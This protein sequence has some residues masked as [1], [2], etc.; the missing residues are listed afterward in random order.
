MSDGPRIVGGVESFLSTLLL[1]ACASQQPPTDS[2]SDEA[3]E[4]IDQRA[5]FQ[6]SQV[7]GFKTLD[8]SNLIVYA[9][10]RTS[11]YHVRIR[12]PARELKFAN[13]IAFDTGG[14]RICGRVGEGV[15]FE[16][17]GMGRKYFVTDVYRLDEEARQNLISSFSE[18]I[19]VE[20]QEEREL[21][22]E[23]DIE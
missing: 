22:I 7:T 18:V 3:V 11:A 2:D 19:N 13:V 8:Q 4:A 5:C 6:A 1:C 17:G 20:P 10:S 12:P 21:E 9:P 16:S 15:L 23:R 14:T